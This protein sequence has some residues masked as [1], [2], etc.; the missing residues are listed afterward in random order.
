[1]IEEYH[2]S[3]Y[4]SSILNLDRFLFCN[5]DIAIFWIFLDISIFWI[6]LN[7]DLI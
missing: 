5:V 4:I 3:I 1:M 6:L 7:K 2:L